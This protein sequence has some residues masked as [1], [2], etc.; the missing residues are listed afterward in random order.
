MIQGTKNKDHKNAIIT[1][2]Y[3]KNIES[4]FKISDICRTGTLSQVRHAY[5]YDFDLHS[6]VEVI[7]KSLLVDEWVAK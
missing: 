5:N 6:C 4:R 2:F 7:P 1:I 3:F